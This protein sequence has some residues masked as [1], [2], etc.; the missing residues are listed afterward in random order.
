MIYHKGKKGPKF[1]WPGGLFFNASS[2]LE[3]GRFFLPTAD[4]WLS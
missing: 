1:V 3:S 4:G 2:F